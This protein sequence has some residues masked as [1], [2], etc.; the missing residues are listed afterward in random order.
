M[1]WPT[2][3]SYKRYAV[4]SWAPVN[5]VWAHDNRTCGF[6]IVGSGSGFRIENRLQRPQQVGRAGAPEDLVDM[7][8]RAAEQIGIVGSVGEQAARDGEFARARNR[9]KAPPAGQF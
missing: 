8:C 6:R 7:R 4:A 2:I 1:F 5:I 3:N 9:G